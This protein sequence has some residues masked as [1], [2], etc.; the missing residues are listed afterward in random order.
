MTDQQ[1]PVDE[2]GVPVIATHRKNFA[3]QLKPA[4]F[5][6]V[7]VPDTPHGYEYV[8]PASLYQAEVLRAALL[9]EKGQFVASFAGTLGY[10]KYVRELVQRA[11]DLWP[12]QGYLL[13]AAPQGAPAAAPQPAP[14]PPQAPQPSAPAPPPAAAP[15]PAPQPNGQQQVQHPAAPWDQQPAAAGVASQAAAQA[16]VPGYQPQPAPQPA[17]P[18]PAATAASSPVIVPPG[19]DAAWC[20]QAYGEFG[21]GWVYD[22]PQQPA[23]APQPAAQPDPAVFASDPSQFPPAP[24][25]P[26]SVEQVDAAPPLPGV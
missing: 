24:T 13:H 4:D 7:A 5:V 23:P 14:A 17:A 12:A 8:D 16:G 22:Q 9:R 11:W 20:T 6:R 21:V 25:P 2:N 26:P 15:A 10:S 19:S 3:P 18:P 1:A